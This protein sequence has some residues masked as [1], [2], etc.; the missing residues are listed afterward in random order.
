MVVLLSPPSRGGPARNARVICQ[1]CQRNVMRCPPCRMSSEVLEPVCLAGV[2]QKK[3]P[4]GQGCEPAK[5]CFPAECSS[6]GCSPR[7]IFHHSGATGD[8]DGKGSRNA[9][10]QWFGR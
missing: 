9:D 1:R 8:Q 2:D 3:Q 6:A 10:A 4:C 7:S 5:P